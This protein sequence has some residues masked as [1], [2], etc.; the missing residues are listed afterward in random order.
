MTTL[1]TKISLDR[2]RATIDALASDEFAGRRVGTPGARLA[3]DWLA[4]QLRGLGADVRE[5][6]FRAAGVREVY[7]TPIMHI[8][9]P[10]EHRRDFA[11]HVASGELAE[12]RTALGAQED[13]PSLRNRWVLATSVSILDRAEAEQT[14]GVILPRGTDADGWMPK[15]ITG[16]SPRRIPILSAR[17]DL[18]A[19]L[20]GRTVTASVPMRTVEATGRNLHGSFPDAGILL[21]AHYDGVGD[22]PEIQLPGAADNASGVAVVLEAARL[23]G[24]SVA[25]L[26]AEEAGALGSAHHA[27]HVPADTVVINVDGA[28][29]LGPTASVEAGGPAHALLAVLDQ[30]GKQVG[31]PLRGAPVASDNRRYAAAGLAAIGIG[32][33]IPGYQTPAETPDRVES[34]TLLAAVRLVVTTVRMLRHARSQ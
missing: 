12:P 31:V 10:L 28:A 15:M 24:V 19:E 7:E 6:H 20:A 5:D 29:K 14:A 4:D 16:P 9:R 23:L 22:D 26:D 33:G 8:G 21:T 11:E 25:L 32:M 3:G 17:S 1:E 34:E 2:M 30:A 13:A 18:H 27:S